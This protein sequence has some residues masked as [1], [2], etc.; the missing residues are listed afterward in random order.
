MNQNLAIQIEG[1]PL[2][3]PEDFSIDYEDVN[4]YFNDNESFSYPV[5]VPI[6]GNRRA[7]GNLDDVNSEERAID[8]DYKQARIIACGIPFRSGR[9]LIDEIGRAHV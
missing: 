8:L 2:A 6:E 1:K 7:L 9:V 3:L 4:P 5:E